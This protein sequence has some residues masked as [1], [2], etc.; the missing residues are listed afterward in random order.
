[1]AKFK[2]IW[3]PRDMDRRDYGVVWF[4]TVVNEADSIYGCKLTFKFDTRR[5]RVKIMPTNL[6]EEK[7]FVE[8]LPEL[9]RGAII[10]GRLTQLLVDRLKPEHIAAA[11][12][13]AILHRKAS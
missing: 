1:M 5:Y 3:G 6:D 11:V 4:F 12:S 2:A 8:A 13:G 7:R 10:E 9:R